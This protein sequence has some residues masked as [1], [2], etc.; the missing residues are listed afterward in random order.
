MREV[1]EETGYTVKPSRFAGL[2]EEIFTDPFLRE[3]YPDY[4]HRLYPIF[5]CACTDAPCAEPTE[6]DMS[7]KGCE[8][9]PLLFLSQMRIL[10]AAVGSQLDALLSGQ[11]ALFLGTG[12][13]DRNHG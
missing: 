2:Y 12:H 7:Q 13:T 9:V 1:W 8:W 3:R 4:T 10:P 5:V 11:G 6:K